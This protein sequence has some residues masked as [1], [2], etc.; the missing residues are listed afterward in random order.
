MRWS[1]A[2]RANQATRKIPT[3]TT[4]N[5]S[6]PP[7]AGHFPGSHSLCGRPRVFRMWASSW[8]SSW[9]A[10]ERFSSVNENSSS[11][12]PHSGRRICARSTCI[13]ASRAR[14]RSDSSSLDG[15]PLVAVMATQYWTGSDL[16]IALTSGVRG[17][18]HRRASADPACKDRRMDDL[19]DDAQQPRWP[20]CRVVM[21]DVPGG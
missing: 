7:H 17:Y 5:R 6:Q 19:F 14:R 21:R 12:S 13:C 11:A 4:V 1:Q 20:D 15:S 8:A 9:S 10:S 18:P 16:E 2:G 3:T